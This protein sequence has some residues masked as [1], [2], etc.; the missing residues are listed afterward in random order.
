MKKSN[1][2][3]RKIYTDILEQKYPEKLEDCKAILS[4]TELSSLD[5]LCLNEKIFGKKT[6]R[7]NSKL[8]SYFKDDI[9]KILEFQKKN[10]L[11]VTDLA[12]HYNL[13]RN[14]ITKWKR[15]YC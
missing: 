9:V 15:L 2:N 4:K 8:H 13:S 5:I 10:C 12:K 14:T 1:V 11:T 3:Y 7:D 6:H